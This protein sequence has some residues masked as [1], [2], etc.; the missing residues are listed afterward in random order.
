MATRYRFLVSRWAVV[1]AVVALALMAAML[2][3]ALP[4]GAQ[5][6][7]PGE[8]TG[9]TAKAVAATTVELSWTAPSAGRAS[10][11]G[12]KIER[13]TDNG[14][15]WNASG[16][17][18][19]TE[20]DTA[21]NVGTG[22]Q[23]YYAV[24]AEAGEN[25]YRVSAIN[26]AGTGDPSI[27]VSV[28]PPTSAQPG[29]P[30]GVTATANGSREINLS[31][32]APDTPGS[33]PVTQYKIEYSKNGR[34]PW[35]ELATTTVTTSDDGTKYSNTGLDPGTTRHYRV[36][37]VNIAGR[38]P[39][40]PTST[41]GVTGG[42]EHTAKTELAGVPAAPTGL[43]ARATAAAGT[44]TVELY[45]TAPNE[46]RAPIENYKIETS[47]DRGATW[48]VSVAT[49]ETE[50]MG[51]GVQ[52]Y[53]DVDA[54]VLSTTVTSNSYRVSAINTIGTGPVS[55]TVTVT[56]P[57]NGTQPDAPAGVMATKDGERQIEV[58]WTKVPSAD[59]GVGPVTQ[60]KIEY[61]KNG[62]LPWM[63][64]ATTAGTAAR[65][66]NTGLAPATTRHYRVSAVNKAG[67]G[68][69]SDVDMVTTDSPSVTSEPGKPT[70]LTAKAVAATTVELSWTAPSAGRASVTG[71]KIE[72][73]T[74]N[75]SSWNAS[76]SVADTEADTA[77]NVGTGVQTYYAVTAEA[78]ENLYRVSAINDAGTGDPSTLVSVTPPT[79]AQPGAPSGVTATANGSREI[80]LS[81]AAP[82]TPGSGPVTQYK[83]EYSKNGRLPWMEL[84]T[85]T[86]TTSDDGTKYSNTGLDPGTTRHYRVSA[87]NIAGRGPVFPT[88]TD[89]VTGGDEHTAKTELA[90]V[91]AAPTGLKA[92]ATAAAGTKTVELY[93]TAPNEGRAPIENYKIET[94]NDRGATWS[95]SVA[96]TETE[97]MGSG[98]QTYHDVD[99]TV[100][101]TT[102][103]SNSYRVSAINTIGT[104]PVSATVTVTAP[105]N[106]TQP[107]APA[108]VM[109][110]ADG[111][112]E[113]EVS[114]TKVPSADTGVGPVT[115]YKI[116]YSKDSMLPWMDLATTAGT[117]ARYEHTGLAPDTER[118]YRVSA[119]NKAGQGPVSAIVSDTTDIEGPLSV[120]GP[121]SSS[122]PE[123]GTAEVGAYTAQGPNA[124]SARLTLD[125]DDRA[126]FRLNRSSTGA[127]M[128]KFSTPP[129]YENP[130]DANK[131]NV[132]EITVKATQGTNTGVQTVVVSVTDVVELGTLEGPETITQDE[133]DTDAAT[134]TTTGPATA[135]WTLD[136]ADRGDFSISGG[137]LRF[138]STPNFEMPADAD[139]D[140]TYEVTVKAEAGGEMGMKS[141][142]VMVTNMDEDGMVT[143]SSMNPVV[144]TKITASLMDP[145]KIVSGTLR[146]EWRRSMDMD[147]TFMSIT[148]ADMPTYTPKADDEGY[149]LRAVAS[150]DDEEA[151]TKEAMATTRKVGT[152]N[153]PVFAETTATRMIAENSAA[154]ATVGDPV[155]ATDADGDTL[156]YMLSGDDAT[157]FDIDNMG[158][159][160]V[161]ENT[162]LDYEAEKMT[163][164]VTVTA[165][166]DSGAPY[167]SD[168]IAVT[169]MVTNEEET[170][171]VTLWAGDDA[172]TM[173][174]QVGDTITG[175]VMD[176]DGGVMGE[177]WQ[178][179]RTMTPDMMDSWMDITG[180]T[181]A[182]YMVM[183]GDT[184][185]Y[186]RVMA[187]YTD[188]AG[189][190]MGYSSATMMVGAMAAD[191]LLAKYDDD[192]DGYIQLGE[193]RDAVGDYFVDPKG[194]E[195]SLVD[196]R[197]VVGLYFEYKNRPPQ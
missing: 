7:P 185:Y 86:V 128:L 75:G 146:W 129:D 27:R 53:H 152:N 161:G 5:S 2:V 16:S 184:G 4:V 9:L 91:P 60:Y 19:D 180:A 167:N 177:S 68:P 156:T 99:A 132:Y 80:N 63:E 11:T 50:N 90:G 130:R 171:E 109:A 23:T 37:A 35:M 64:L 8:P 32:A 111:S 162:M 140:N 102:V 56:A 117:A 125:G 85:T 29:A 59:T 127:Y 116:E 22:V 188:A 159:I 31:W 20:A 55:A 157:Y 82:D 69:A 187:T 189:M 142:M 175:A 49:T 14:S 61:S 138:R 45:W 97:N 34:L 112:A 36:S 110:R 120:T 62:M 139:R 67:R 151:I 115:Q 72:R 83:I 178:W 107:D 43:K 26:D 174:P 160:K 182:A 13:S 197:K 169:I 144:D 168:S 193:A 48:S 176:P 42:D 133:N 173:A 183:E 172:L 25:L 179:S 46:G 17:V 94:S 73:S 95:V 114:W 131:D 15:S 192:K 24:T 147:S 28:T 137:M 195:L 65:Y 143:L 148:G 3:T 1:P 104:G 154:E 103:T 163:Y 186:L 108:G 96:T 74:D 190:D 194:S 170:G 79:S 39:V 122:Y 10:V 87:V 92:R 105:V 66:E 98:V 84:A 12:Y 121:G 21:Q 6:S 136:G 38:G 118:H 71:Y 119:V 164:M 52:T 191:P 149:Y 47:N 40:F 113:I 155:M 100:L 77:Q 81:W 18:A 54:T 126:S 89:G 44:K 124:A 106:G 58:S 145:D 135:R 76:G 166:D 78:G 158:Q 153:A 70:G 165:T 134:Y 33:G 101:S 123:N 30:S 181:D 93:W 196:A 141:V 41:D 51:S 150:Y 57:V 88:S